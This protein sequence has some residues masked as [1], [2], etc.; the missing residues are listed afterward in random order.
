VGRAEAAEPTMIVRW[1]TGAM[2]LRVMR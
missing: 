2:R 1:C